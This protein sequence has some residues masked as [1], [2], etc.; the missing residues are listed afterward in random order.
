VV[1]VTALTV[2]KKR[3]RERDLKEASCERCRWMHKSKATTAIATE[4]LLKF[5]SL[6][7]YKE[8]VCEEDGLKKTKT[9]KRSEKSRR[10]T[11]KR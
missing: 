2:G 4:W 6:Y 9:N 8:R 11:K 1:D 7:I 5:P 3:K 10:Y